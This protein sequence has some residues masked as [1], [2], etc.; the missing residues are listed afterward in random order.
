MA[1]DPIPII[2]FN[3]LHIG[4]EGEEVLRITV[5]RASLSGISKNVAIGSWLQEHFSDSVPVLKIRLRSEGARQEEV[6]VVLREFRKFVDKTMGLSELHGFFAHTKDASLIQAAR[7]MHAAIRPATPE[8][9]ADHKQ[10]TGED[11]GEPK[12]RVHEKV[13]N[14]FQSTIQTIVRSVEE[15]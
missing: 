5:G 15:S 3:K 10:E 8:E 4:E 1:L 13:R 6:D 14:L 2:T 7:D 12:G 9:I 11:F